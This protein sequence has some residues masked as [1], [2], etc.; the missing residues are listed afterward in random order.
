VK[1]L[2]KNG[3]PVVLP[4]NF[5][6]KVNTE[7]GKGKG[8]GKFKNYKVESCW[9][10]ADSTRAINDW[11]KFSIDARATTSATLT[12]RALGLRAFAKDYQNPERAKQ[13]I[14]MAEA[15]E[16]AERVLRY[17]G[18]SSDF[19]PKAWEKGFKQGKPKRRKR[20]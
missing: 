14:K 15:L 6:I 19:V 9:T 17:C 12:I 7:K 16:A 5:T 18:P 8:L 13:Y 1:P 11:Q 3:K 20:S 4:M 10:H 2:T